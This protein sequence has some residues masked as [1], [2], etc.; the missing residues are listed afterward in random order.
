[1]KESQQEE[2]PPAEEGKLVYNALDLNNLETVEN[3][4]AEQLKDKMTE[5]EKALKELELTTPEFYRNDTYFTLINNQRVTMKKGEQA[6]Y[7]YG[8]RTNAFLLISYGFCPKNNLYDSCKFQL[9]L[10]IDVTNGD[11]ENLRQFFY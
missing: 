2:D 7:C 10:D 3:L 11:L 6:W 8:R 4:H 5:E 1:M 9:R